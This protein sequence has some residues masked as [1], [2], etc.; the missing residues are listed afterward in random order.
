LQEEEIINL[1]N[2][3]FKKIV[4]MREEILIDFDS[5]FFSNKNLHKRFN[6]NYFL[7]KNSHNKYKRLISHNIDII[8]D[9]INSGYII[10]MLKDDYLFLK[11]SRN[12]K[13]EILFN[14]YRVPF[15][16]K[17]FFVDNKGN[18]KDSLNEFKKPL[19]K[20]IDIRDIKL[21]DLVTNDTIDYESNKIHFINIQ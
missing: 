20:T 21:I 1:R 4:D 2:K 10:A 15:F 11:S 13:L 17:S 6:E 19:D 5:I 14:D 18:L 9:Y 16:S 12:N 8:D 7:M 3:Y